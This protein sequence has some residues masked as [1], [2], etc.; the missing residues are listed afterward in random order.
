MSKYAQSRKWLLTIN[1]PADHDLD[2]ENIKRI[3]SGIKN[4]GY[5][6]MCD[7]IGLKDKTYHTHVFIY[8]KSPIKF[9]YLKDNFPQAHIDWCNGTCLQNRDYVRKEG[10]YLGSLKEDTNLKDTFEEFGQCPEEHQGK[11]SDLDTLYEF[12]KDGMSDAEIIDSDPNYIKHI[13]K[14]DRCRQLLKAEQ[15]KNIFRE[16][17]VQ[18]WYGVTG[19][20]KTRTVMD[21]WGYEN[22]Y[23]VSDYT[24]PFDTYKC[25]DVLILDEFRSDLKIGLMLNLLDGYPLDLPC[26]YNNKVACF[27]KVYIISNVSLDQQYSNMQRDQKDTWQAFLRRIKTV[28][29]F[30]ESGLKKMGSPHDFLYGFS[31]VPK[32]EFIPFEAPAVSSGTQMNINDF[33]PFN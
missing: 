3:L 28:K 18:Y 25:Q 12:I 10:K 8:R 20:G 9:T 15:Y 22:V 30:D 11:R 6:C 2:H 7:E 14:I 13:D 5:Y 24:H 32:D 4:I 17:D 19:S 16:L 29:F 21:H 23:R 31:E 27:T 26:R 33:A 1:N